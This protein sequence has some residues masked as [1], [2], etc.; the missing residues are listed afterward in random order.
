MPNSDSAPRRRGGRPPRYPNKAERDAHQ[1]GYAAGYRAGQRKA[2]ASS[3]TNS[4]RDAWLAVYYRVL[5]L[6][7]SRFAEPEAAA[8]E[9]ANYASVAIIEAANRG[10]ID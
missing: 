6:V 9:A 3:A 5:P 7:P 2:P 1:R 4:R 8:K 10:F